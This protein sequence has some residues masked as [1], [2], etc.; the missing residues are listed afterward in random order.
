MEPG[1][2][3]PLFPTGCCGA[4]RGARVRACKISGTRQPK[5]PAAVA[6]L[7]LLGAM[8]GAGLSGCARPSGRVIIK[9]SDTMVALGQRF[10]EEF[11]LRHPDIIVSVTGGGSGTGIAALINGT[12]DIAQASRKIK[13]KEV[14]RAR[15]A[16]IEPIEIVVAWDGIAV[17]VNP[18]NPVEK[19]TLEQLSDIFQGKITDWSQ[20]TSG[21]SG[22]IVLLARESTSGTHVFFK[23][24]VLQLDGERPD[25]DYARTAI[26]A[27]SNETIHG[28]VA[29][30]P[31]A[32][33]YVGIGFLDDAVKAVAV[34]ERPEG[35][36]VKPTVET[37]LSKEYPIARPLFNY[38]AGEPKGA[39]KQYIDFVLSPEGQ[40][41]VAD[42]GFVPIP[43]GTASGPSK[44]PEGAEKGPGSNPEGTSAA[45][46][47]ASREHSAAMAAAGHGG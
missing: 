44:A 4:H 32:I 43:G 35:P 40:A 21:M 19:L 39:V 5:L 3:S 47:G 16:G 17:I 13:P 20:V 10:A 8:V 12:C 11:M 31:K 41:V 25:A 9:G 26:L 1:K 45:P 14:E 23:E 7:L 18:K 38:V 29:S 22:K 30:N 36:Y 42:I 46:A 37:I 27:G 28:E 2:Y 24:R 6:Y 15:K 33:G 34:A